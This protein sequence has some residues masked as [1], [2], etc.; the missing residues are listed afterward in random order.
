MMRNRIVRKK[1]ERPLPAPGGLLLAVDL[2]VDR[3]L[4]ARIR[5]LRSTPVLIAFSFRPAGRNQAGYFPVEKE[6]DAP[7]IG[8]SSGSRT[9]ST[10]DHVAQVSRAPNATVLSIIPEGFRVRNRLSFDC[11]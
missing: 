11:C 2:D 6:L 8:A 1:S 3:E 10:S 4:R 9:D 7:G 5:F